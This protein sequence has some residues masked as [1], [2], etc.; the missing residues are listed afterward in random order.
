M[1]RWPEPLRVALLL[2]PALTVV[3]VFFVGGVAQA[4]LQSL[5]H[6]PLLG[7]STW[8]LDAYRAVLTDPAFVASLLL[9]MRVAL[10]STGVATVLGV[11]LA[12]LVRRVGGRARM[13]ALF[14]GTLAIPHLVGALSI[15]LLLAPS[16][17]LSRVGQALGLVDDAQSFPVLTQDAFGWGIIAEYV[18]KETPFIAVVALAALSR[19]VGELEGV[20]RTLGAGAGQR[21]RSVTIP[22]L[23]PPVAAASVLVFAFTM[24]SYEVPRLLGRPFPAMLPVEAFQRFRDTDLGVR[25]EAMA[26]ATV[27]AVLSIVVVLAYLRLVAGLTRRQV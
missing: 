20:A 12:L 1:R 17:L 3:G 13:T 21:L 5:G 26:I 14:H 24:A 6:Q 19:G 23:A 18:W 10:I 22:L 2:A 11:G 25:P 8:S 16:G 15:G 27:L 4:V 7:E 9:T